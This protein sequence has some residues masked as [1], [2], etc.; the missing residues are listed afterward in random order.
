MRTVAGGEDAQCTERQDEDG[1]KT[2]GMF[3]GV[4]NDEV[5]NL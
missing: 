1:G 4:Q 3:R 5:P 2:R